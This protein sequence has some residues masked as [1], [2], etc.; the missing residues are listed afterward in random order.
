MLWEE[1]VE[2]GMDFLKKSFSNENMA[3][4]GIMRYTGRKGI[5]EETIWF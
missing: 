1:D 2:E 4:G 3:Q 5:S